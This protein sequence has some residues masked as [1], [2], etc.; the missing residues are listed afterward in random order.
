[1]SG[2]GV[3]GA[4][5]DVVLRPNGYTPPPYDPS[6]MTPSLGPL[7]TGGPAPLSYT[8]YGFP[9]LGQASEGFAGLSIS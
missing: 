2:L 1:M 9:S 3:S 8:D 4:Y 7:A 5:S 6:F